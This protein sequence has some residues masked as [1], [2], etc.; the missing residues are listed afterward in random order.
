M[1]IFFLI[2]IIF[3]LALLYCCTDLTVNAQSD[4]E[5]TKHRNIIIELDNGLETNARLNLPASSDGPFPGVLLVHGSGPL[6]MNETTGVIR[7]DNDTGSITYP[8]SRP[9]FEIAQYL[10]ERGFAVL[11]YNKRG[12]GESF[13]VLDS[14]VWGMPQ[15]K[16]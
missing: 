2:M 4:L 13:T 11:Q 14:N 6:D 7:I 8:S 12:I 16:I 3:S 1:K 15:F 5:T 9:Y 10:S